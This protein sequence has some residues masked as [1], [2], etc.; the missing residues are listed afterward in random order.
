MKK[1]TLKA[2]ANKVIMICHLILNAVLFVAYVGEYLKGAKTLGFT[3]F[4]SA[5]TIIPS[6]LDIV[7]FRGDPESDILKHFI[8]IS[9]AVLNTVAMFTSESKLTFTYMIIIMVCM[10]LYLD[11]PYFLRIGIFTIIVNGIDVGYKLSTGALTGADSAD[12]E[13]RLALLVVLVIFTYIITKKI[14]EMN[15]EKQAEIIGE[16][17][18]TEEMLREIID[19]SNNMT[20]AITEVNTNMSTLAESTHTMEIAMDEVSQGNHE[21]ADSIQNQ[22]VHTDEIQNMIDTIRD[23]G[24]DIAAGM[25]TALTEVTAG[26]D[27][28]EALSRLA[29]KSDQANETV[30]SL[31]N[32]LKDQT[33]KMNDI[34]VMITSIANSTGMLALNASIEA[35]RA[36]EA[37]KGFAV[38]ATQVSELADQTKGASAN[39]TELI[40]EVVKELDNVVDAVGVLKESTGEEDVKITELKGNLGAIT[41]KTREAADKTQDMKDM[42]VKLAQANEEIVNQIQTIS[43]VTEE[44]TARSEQT[45]NACNENTK[46]VNEVT[47]LAETLNNDAK[48]L[49]QR[50]N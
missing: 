1:L 37:G 2:Q 10:M 15:K 6:V 14:D 9:F 30:V 29:E 13:I 25:S 49:A 7:L 32:E 12:I 27:N 8:P 4:F 34:I 19:L 48:A 11:P 33:K 42:V 39:I 16:K 5:L 41:D 21:T 35:A 17:E 23:I 18:R 20:G 28:M 38:V 47:K 40:R 24:E 36:G 43:A 31:V 50:A 45:L 46:I 26:H 22:A 3:L 44:V